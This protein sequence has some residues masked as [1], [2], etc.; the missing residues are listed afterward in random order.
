VADHWQR[1]H[2]PW[3]HR[4]PLLSDL[5]RNLEYTQLRTLLIEDQ[6]AHRLQDLHTQARRFHSK[7]TAICQLLDEHRTRH[8]EFSL[9]SQISALRWGQLRQYELILGHTRC[10][11]S[12]TRDDHQLTENSPLPAEIA[13]KIPGLARD[14]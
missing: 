6:S 10:Q 4:L 14:V 2:L 11:W 7:R 13:G 9:S 12:A 1:R 8:W 5:V 3:G